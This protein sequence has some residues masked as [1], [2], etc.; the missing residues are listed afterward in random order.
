MAFSGSEP[1]SDPRGSRSILSRYEDD[2]ERQ[3]GELKESFDVSLI[4][5]LGQL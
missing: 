5:A 1:W 4:I 3:D 2:L